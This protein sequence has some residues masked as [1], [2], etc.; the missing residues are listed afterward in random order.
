MIFCGNIFRTPSLPN[1]QRQGAEILREG[2]SPPTGLV[3][4][5]TCY[6]SNFMFH[7]SHVINFVL[8]FFLLFFL[9][10][11]RQSGETSWWRV[12]YKRGYSAQFSNQSYSKQKSVF[13]LLII[14]FCICNVFIT[15]PIVL[16]RV[17]LKNFCIINTFET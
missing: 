6:V 8:R 15:F 17:E 4:C 13:V 3:S 1:R 9:L 12:C 16:S 7:M 14:R 11:F 2:S 10:F 5:V